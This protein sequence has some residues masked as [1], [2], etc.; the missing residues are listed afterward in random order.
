MGIDTS[1]PQISFGGY[2]VDQERIRK[3]AYMYEVLHVECL[4][5]SFVWYRGTIIWYIW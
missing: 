5:V 4:Y 2:Y 1:Y 3:G